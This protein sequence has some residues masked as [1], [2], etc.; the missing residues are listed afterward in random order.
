MTLKKTKE[1]SDLD[2][3]KIL[4]VGDY[5]WPWYQEACAKTLEAFGCKVERFGWLDDFYYWKTGRSEPVIHSLL[6]RLQSRLF[7]GP[8]IWK[9]NRRLI[10]YAE[11]T[12]P[13]IVWFYN[14]QLISSTTVKKLRKKL[15]N[16]IFCQYANDNPFSNNA[17]FGLWR[18]FLGSIRYFDLHFAYRHS[19]IIDYKNYGSSKTYLLRS[20]FIPEFDYNVPQNTISEAFKCDVV[21]AGHYEDDGRLEI[22]ESICNSGFKLKLYGGGWN[23]AMSKLKSNSKLKKLFPI[24]PVTGEYYRFA[25]CGAKVALCFLSKLNNDTYTRRNFQI[26]AM[27]TAMLSQ[28]TDDLAKLFQPDKEI[29]F[30]SNQKELMSKLELLL[31]D[32]TLRVKIAEAGYQKVYA[33]GHDIGSRMKIWLQETLHCQEKKFKAVDIDSKNKLN[34]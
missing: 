12:R 31:S 14:V 10:K 26:P 1:H 28:Y 7:F 15:P 9:V 20:Y 25:I 2:N 11:Q 8:I 21:F 5:M 34:E 6:H 19:N 4:L 17:K 32:N 16:A 18:N 24:R 30:F 33:D 27:K 29:M 13:D 22:L 3:P 23:E